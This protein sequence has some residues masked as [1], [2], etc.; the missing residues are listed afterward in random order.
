L[1]RKNVE[2]FAD[3]PEPELDD[4]FRI[5]LS[6]FDRVDRFVEMFWERVFRRILGDSNSK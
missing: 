5:R 4:L 2:A 6:F 3:I 1:D